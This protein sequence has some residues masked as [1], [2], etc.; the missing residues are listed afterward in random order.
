MHV[1]PSPPGVN[2][3]SLNC[4]PVAISTSALVTTRQASCVDGP[5]PVGAAVTEAAAVAVRDPGVAEVPGVPAGVV[6]LAPRVTV[7][8]VAVI[9][10]VALEAALGA[11]VAVAVAAGVGVALPADGV[12]VGLPLSPPQAASSHDNPTRSDNRRTWNLLS[13]Y[14]IR[15][16]SC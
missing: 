13:A 4:R 12:L 6:G 7:L 3:G 15:S 10:M 9:V 5:W 11:A 8:G 14:H 2:V 16:P 1:P